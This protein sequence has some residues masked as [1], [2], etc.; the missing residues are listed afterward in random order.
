VFYILLRPFVLLSMNIYYRIDMRGFKN[1]PRNVP[2]VLAP[3]HSNGFI[4]P[5]ILGVY[6][7]QKV[8]FFARGDAFKGKFA[9]WILNKMNVSPMYRLQEGYA[10]LKKNDKTFEE[11]KQLL[12]NNKTILLFPEAICVYERR[13]RPL[14]KGVARIVFQTSDSFD[15]NKD[16]KVIPV[17]I[18]YTAGKRFRSK[19]FIDIGKPLSVKEYDLQ[20]KQD[21]VKTINSFTKVLEEKMSEHVINIENPV[22][23]ELVIGIEEI[24]T[25]Q[26]LKDKKKSDNKLAYQYEAAKEIVDMVNSLDKNEPELIVSLRTKIPNYLKLLKSNGLRDHLLR[27][28]VISKMNV[29]TFILEYIIIYLGMPIYFL[30]L[31]MNYPPYLFT[32]KFT[33]KKIKKVEFYASFRANLSFIVWTF[34]FLIQ[35]AVIGIVFHSWQALLIFTVLVAL[36]GIFVLKYYPVMKKIF[37]RWRLLRIVRKERS[38]IEQLVDERNIIINEL[39]EVKKIYLETLR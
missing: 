19:V 29:G 39:R 2:L 1:I 23:D 28:D 9:R 15:F 14:K 24:Y 8:R 12:T 26:W 17:G 13:L 33:D 6:I 3:N 11:C 34:Y 10:E 7:R 37:G 30:G 4:D 22:N 27:P 36:S 16:I 31:I 25:H 20:Y 32:E 21:K 18:N 35:L 38:T 5:I